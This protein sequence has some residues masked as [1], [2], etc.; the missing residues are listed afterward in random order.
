MKHYFKTEWKEF[1]KSFKLKINFVYVLLFD[2]VFA[3]FSFLSV[4][5]FGKIAQELALKISSLDIQDAATLMESQADVIKSVLN[6]LLIYAVLLV[7]I[8]FAICI[9]TQSLI[10]N[11]ILKK[12][13]TWKYIW[14]FAVLN[15]IWLLWIAPFILI[16]LT[17]EPTLIIILTILLGILFIHFTMILY[18]IFTRE[19]KIGKALKLCFKLGVMKIR[20]YLIPILFAVIIFVL[21]NLIMT[22]INMAVTSVLIGLA[23]LII[24]AAWLRFYLSSVTL[25]VAKRI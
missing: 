7:I 5:L 16:L 23:L 20:L 12:K 13:L 2:A 25:R 14:K 22:L 19:V 1:L 15:I 24:F 3:A 17:K 9:I 6:S 8:L 10:W 11:T 4:I 21:L 18:T